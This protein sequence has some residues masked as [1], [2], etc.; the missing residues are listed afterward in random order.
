MLEEVEWMCYNALPPHALYCCVFFLD[1]S[2]G[3][4]HPCFCL[5]LAPSFLSLLTPLDPVSQT[6]LCLFVCDFW[7]SYLGIA[8]GTVNRG[9][10]AMLVKIVLVLLTF[11]LA[12][13]SFSCTSPS[14]YLFTLA[15]PFAL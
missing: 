11:T 6:L 4:Q 13:S 3:Y 5:L 7:S 1:L 9:C 8:N 15:A 12:L 14:L 2:L 10:C